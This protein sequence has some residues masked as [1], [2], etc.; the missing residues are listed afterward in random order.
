MKKESNP[1]PPEG[2]V[3]PPPPPSPPARC[4]KGGV[5]AEKHLADY[6]RS[7]ELLSAIS[8]ELEYVAFNLCDKSD[9]EIEQGIVES[10]CAE[11]TLFIAIR[12]LKAMSR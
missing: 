7:D 1:P 4:I 10:T 12:K 6:V 11:T 3:K 5:P 2:A 8:A 9:D